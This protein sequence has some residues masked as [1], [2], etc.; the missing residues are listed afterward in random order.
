MLPL[1][2]R[3]LGAAGVGFNLSFLATHGITWVEPGNQTLSTC[4]TD[5]CAIITLGA[6]LKLAESN[7]FEP[8]HPFLDDGLANR[9][10]NPS[11]NF[12]KSGGRCEIRTHGPVTASSFQ[13]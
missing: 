9:C 3:E 12:P 8:L 6:T 2:Q 7:G 4:F 10:L 13:D 5:K 1:H 11:A